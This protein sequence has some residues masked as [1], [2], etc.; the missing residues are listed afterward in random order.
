MIRRQ[1]VHAA[2]LSA[3]FAA[4]FVFMTADGVSAAS[5][6]AAWTAKQPACERARPLNSVNFPNP[7]KIDNGFLPLRP[8][9]GFVLKGTD[10][11][12]DET[13]ARRVEITVTDLTKAIN[14]VR[15]IVVS[16]RDFTDDMLTE[17]EIAFRA[18]EGSG[19]WVWEL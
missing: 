12:D 17:D 6:S 2:L 15:A 7:P 19:K 3:P 1:R 8:G 18:Q 4:S 5:T 10:G 9:V 11:D 14:G 16:E 13:V